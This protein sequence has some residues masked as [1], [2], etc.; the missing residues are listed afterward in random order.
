MLQLL[1]ILKR[2]VNSATTEQNKHHLKRGLSTLKYYRMPYGFVKQ[3]ARGPRTVKHNMYTTVPLMNFMVHS[4][5]YYG[6]YS[7]AA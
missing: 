4:I 3:L 6:F 1:E 5:C 2:K 7:P